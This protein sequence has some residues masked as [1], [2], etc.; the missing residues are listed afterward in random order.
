[1]LTLQGVTIAARAMRVLAT[2]VVR[3]VRWHG[4]ESN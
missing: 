1:M 3:L 4:S 2:C